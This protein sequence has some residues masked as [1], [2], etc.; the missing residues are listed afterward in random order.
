MS[1][2]TAFAAASIFILTPFLA[3]FAERAEPS[4]AIR[5][6]VNKAGDVGAEATLLPRFPGMTTDRPFQQLFYRR[7]R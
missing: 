5:R 2:A 6:L 7:L 1:S 4:L 3:R